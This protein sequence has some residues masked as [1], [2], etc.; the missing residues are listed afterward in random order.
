VT[1]RL[2]YIW[3]GIVFIFSGC[4][5][6]NEDYLKTGEISEKEAVVIMGI[7]GVDNLMMAEFCM[8]NG[9]D[10]YEFSNAKMNDVMIVK[11]PVP[12][13]T[14][15]FSTYKL[16]GIQETFSI[17]IYVGVIPV[18]IPMSMNGAKI[19]D[20]KGYA[21]DIPEKGIYYYGTFNMDTMKFDKNF[22][23]NYID[24]AKYFYSNYLS[25]EPLAN[26]TIIN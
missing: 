15:Y 17:P 22:D 4:T 24:K 20:S 26:S 3:F 8:D 19:L 6:Y 10:K 21:I 14:F 16:F 7:H 9:C 25:N 11:V 23:E 1:S 12:Q 18:P 5:I 13:K 2:K